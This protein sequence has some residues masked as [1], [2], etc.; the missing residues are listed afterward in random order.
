MVPPR[1]SSID[2]IGVGWVLRFWVLDS[3]NGT[4]LSRGLKGV[5]HPDGNLVLGFGSD[6]L[7]LEWEVLVFR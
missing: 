3:D 1:T 7:E 2:R 5:I 6:E 4:R